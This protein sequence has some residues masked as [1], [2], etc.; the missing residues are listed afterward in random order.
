MWRHPSSRS[1]TRPLRALCWAAVWF[2][3]LG[4]TADDAPPDPLQ[5]CVD[6]AAQQANP[7]NIEE[8]VERLNS[9]PTPITIPC[10]L[11]SLQRHIDVIATRSFLSAQPSGGEGSPRM[12]VQLGDLELSVVPAG[13][14]VDLLEFGEFVSERHTVKGEIV[15][16][17]EQPALLSAPFES[18]LFEPGT[19]ATSCGFC[20]NDESFER[21]VLGVPAFKSL[22]FQPR[23]NLLLSLEVVRAEYQRCDWDADPQ[24]CEML[25]SVFAFGQVREGQFD[26]SLPELGQGQ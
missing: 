7:S 8:A 19:P 22:A 20:H 17:I 14:G 24:R 6:A 23:Y 25:H 3:L 13:L 12:F 10:M 2:T 11:A 16:P 18:I 26:P 5:P 21:T 9:L 1:P 15:M 4:C